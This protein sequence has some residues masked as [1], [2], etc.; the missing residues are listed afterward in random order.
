MSEL[1][2]SQQLMLKLSSFLSRAEFLEIAKIN[3][4]CNEQDDTPIGCRLRA[5]IL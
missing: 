3:M 2:C 5:A 1:A 4:V